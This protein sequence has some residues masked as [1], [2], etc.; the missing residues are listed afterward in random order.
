MSG[1]EEDHTGHCGGCDL[2]SSSE[3]EVGDHIA[4]IGFID[5]RTDRRILIRL[6]ESL[7]PVSVLILLADHDVVDVVRRGL[8]NEN[9]LAGL[10]KTGNVGIVAIHGSGIEIIDR[11]RRLCRVQFHNLQLLRI[12]DDIKRRSGTARGRLQLDT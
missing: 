11:T 3:S 2:R 9:P 6:D 4:L 10:R 8:L 7:H 12:R 5:V 1:T